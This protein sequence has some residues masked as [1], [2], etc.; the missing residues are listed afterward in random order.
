MKN[1]TNKISLYGGLGNQMFQYALYL[2]LK[3]NGIKSRISIS[4]FLIQ[5]HHNG[6]DLARAFKV[7][8][9]IK[10]RILFLLLE[11]GNFLITNRYVNFIL[12]KTI[13]GIQKH[14]LAIYKEKK[15]FRMDKDILNVKPSFIV[16][17]WQSYLYFNH[18]R[19]IVL[20]EF[21]F[22]RPN[23]VKNRATINLI[24]NTNSVSI[25]IRRGD[26]LNTQ[27]QVTHHVIKK[28]DYY[29]RAIQ[30]INKHVQEP[31]FFIFS[32]DIE[33][34][35]VAFN[36][37]PNANYITH[38]INKMSYIDMYLMSICKHNIIANSTFSWWGA[39]LNQNN[40]KIVTSPNIWLNGIDCSELIP[41]EWKLIDI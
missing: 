29:F 28:M 35:K 8:L 12:W 30:H 11:H 41:K 7:Q 34:T 23:D 14:N 22:I 10:N 6:F 25:H 9:S 15:E 18:I 21:T 38:N 2:F 33:W 27:W 5:D 26:Y 20:K 32:D 19:E 13:P 31:F 37:L 16:G 36:G 3:S 4:S 17:T 40:D 1:N 24:K 39:W